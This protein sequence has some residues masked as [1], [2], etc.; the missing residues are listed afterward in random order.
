MDRLWR[1]DEAGVVGGDDE[2]GAVARAE[3][4]QQAADVGLGGRQ[5]DMQM[6][7]DLG[8]G[9]PESDQ[10]QDFAFPL[11]YLVKRGGRALPAVQGAW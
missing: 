10:G 9:E 7:R 2:L 4:H 11:G 8:V 1:A 3:F 6:G 5:A